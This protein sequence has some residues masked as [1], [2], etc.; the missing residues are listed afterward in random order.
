MKISSKKVGC[1]SDIHI[2]LGQDSKQWHDIAINFAKWASKT[3]KDLGI[4]E[5]LIPGDIFHNRSEIGVSTLAVAKEFFDYFKDFTVYIS[6]GNHDCFYKNNST[7]NSISIL[8]GWSNIQII[9]KDCETIKTPYKDIVMV[10]WGV[11]YDQIPQTDGIIFGHFEISS[12]YMNSY[13]VCEHGMESKQL[14]KKAPLIISG[15]FHK[16]DDRK[17]DKGRIVYLG[18]PYQHNFGDIGDARGIYIL[19]LEKNELEFIENNISPKHL[20]LSTKAFVENPESIDSAL[21]NKQLENNIV[22]L[23]VDTDIAQEDLALLSSK[24]HK[25]AL[26]SIRTDYLQDNSSIS[27]NDDSK[28]FD[29]GNLLKDIEEFVENLD[30]ENKQE[31]IE[32]LTETYNLLSK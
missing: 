12:F 20:K 32:Y 10:P 25:K 29:S 23:I 6:S 5:I 26:L 3:Y 17:Y 8:D 2:G 15:H 18:S 21:L 9:D 31:V 19:D 13:K 7:V 16:K 1:F 11:E 24:L 4:D 28:E 22:S 30:I 27:Q 14:F